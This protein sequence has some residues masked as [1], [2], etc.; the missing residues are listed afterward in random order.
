MSQPKLRFVAALLFVEALAPGL[1]AQTTFTVDTFADLPD[2]TALG[3]GVVDADLVAAG[4]QITLRGAIQE[5]SA[6]MGAETIVLPAGVFKLKIKGANENA[7]ATGD[8]DI[9]GDIEILGSGLGATIVDAK[10]AKDRI[11]HLLSGTLE[12]SDLRL[13]N[14]KVADRG[15]AVLAEPGSNLTLVRCIVEKCKAGEDGGGVSVFSAGISVT[16][17]YFLKNRA[18]DDGGALDAVD[19]IGGLIANRCTF[20]RNRAK[21]EGGAIE[22]SDGN[23]S[24]TNSTFDRNKAKFGGGLSFEELGDHTITN[25]T[26]AKN[27]AKI[28]GSGINEDVLFGGASSITIANTIVA[29]SK[30][31]NYFGDGMTSLGGNLDSGNT[32]GFTQPT[33]LVTTDPKLGSLADNGGETP[34]IALKLTSPAID[35]ANDAQSPGI[36]Q[37]GLKRVDI[38]MVGTATSDIGAY[39]V[40]IG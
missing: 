25:C 9:V 23:S 4:N 29:N 38:P 27:K 37:R 19:P 20:S 3:D 13:R 12:L 40:H 26:L 6:L 18:K 30:K 8:L 34:T 11:F 16:D 22:I 33:D 36:D 39:E 32:C 17:S 35:S 2:A 14:G 1:L 10:S 21:E 5:A 31:T 7:S 24:F 15:G 28:R